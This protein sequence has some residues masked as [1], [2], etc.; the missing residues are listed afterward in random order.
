MAE[1]FAVLVL[2]M[3]ATSEEC[4]WARPAPEAPAKKRQ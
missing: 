2:D 4:D 3:A 1:T